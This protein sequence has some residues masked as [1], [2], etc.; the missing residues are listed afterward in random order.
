[1]NYYIQL[2]R[3]LSL[4]FLHSPSLP[5]PCPA[6]APWPV[7]LALLWP[8]LLI[9]LLHTPSHPPLI[10]PTTLLLLLQGSHRLCRKLL[11]QRWPDPPQ[12]SALSDNSFLSAFKTTRED[13]LHSLLGL[14]L[15]LY[16]S[17]SQ[18]SAKSSLP[19]LPPLPQA[20][21]HHWWCIKD[22]HSPVW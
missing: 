7:T 11:V 14:S 3:A 9:S 15:F 20:L 22:L 19:K 17:H 1:M 16:T 21:T 8:P 2:L 10:S 18:V 13:N 5:L 12:V 6:Q 4:F